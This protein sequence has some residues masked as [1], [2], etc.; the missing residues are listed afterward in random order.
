MDK[1]QTIELWNKC[2]REKKD[3]LER[4]CTE[5]AAQQAAAKVWN[6]WAREAQRNERQS[7]QSNSPQEG[8]DSNRIAETA[9]DFSEVLFDQAEEDKVAAVEG[10][11]LR[12][13]TVVGSSGS[14]I[15]FRWFIFPGKTRFY[16]NYFQSWVWFGAN[17][18]YGDLEFSSCIFKS[19][20]GFFSNQALDKPCKFLGTSR[21]RDNI[22]HDG[23]HFTKAEFLGLA[24]FEYS[25]FSGLVQMS[26]AR[27]FEGATFL[28]ASFN[29]GLILNGVE[30]HR[31]P[32]FT[33]ADFKVPPAIPR[34]LIDKGIGNAVD[35]SRRNALSTP[36]LE[37]AYRALKRISNANQDWASEK[38]YFILE[39]GQRS[40]TSI[41]HKVLWKLYK[42]TS[43]YGRS[44][45]LPLLWWLI[46]ASIFATAY[47]TLGSSTYDKSMWD[48]SI[49][50]EIFIAIS[51]N[52]PIVG[53]LGSSQFELAVKS[54][55]ADNP[56]LLPVFG[57]LSIGQGFISAL[58]IFLIGLG[59]RNT[60]KYDG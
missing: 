42:V 3:C 43:N 6:K 35:N 48:N 41:G 51:Q 21:F 60:L 18:F 53:R 16:R 20:V 5:Q 26:D 44:I 57:L 47:R 55:F 28:G 46:A 11:S 31:V 17:I 54:L 2:Q 27:F 56:N 9:V 25:Q 23:V 58:F 59:I 49:P 33:F 14:A 12:H 37:A 39:Q 30:F 24:D 36:T 50:P 1:Q 29:M 10:P 52:F 22:F 8:Q 34:Q 40:N 19:W 32:D 38:E 4:G 45:W 13:E 7:C 15:D